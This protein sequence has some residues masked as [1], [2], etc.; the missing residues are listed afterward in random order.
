MWPFAFIIFFSAFLLFQVQPLIS[1]FILPWFGGS[2]SV[3][4]V[5]MLFFQLLLLLGYLYS[6][7]LNHFKVKTQKYVHL[8]LIFV[9][10]L[11]LPII[12]EAE[13]KPIDSSWP[14]IKIIVILFLTVGLPYFVL[15]TTGPLLQAWYVRKNPAKNPYI[16]Y[17]LSNAGSLIGLIS[18]P[19]LFEPFLDSFTQAWFWSGGFLLF[20]L[21]VFV[22]VFK[23]LKALPEKLF[24]ETAKENIK[25]LRLALWIIFPALASAIF[26][27]VTNHICL[28]VATIPFLW[29]LPFSLY[30]LTFIITFADPYFYKRGFYIAASLFC[31]AVVPFLVFYREIVSFDISLQ[32]V[33][34][35]LV[36]FVTC[37]TCHG[38]LYRL[39]PKAESLTYYYLMIAI[40]GALGGLFVSVIAPLIFTAYWELPFC[41]LALLVVICL[42]HFGSNGFKTEVS[43]KNRKVIIICF[44]LL[45][46]FFI[47]YII[48]AQKSGAKRTIAAQRNFYGTLRVEDIDSRE[49][50]KQ[51][52]YLLYGSTV[53]GNSLREQ[54]KDIPYL[55]YY[56]EGSGVG[57]L[58]EEIINT[59]NREVAL[60]GLGT[61]TLA[62]YGNEGDN[63][64]FY[65]IN[66]AVLPYAE[67][68]F[69]YLKESRAKINHVLGDARLSLEKEPN[70]KFDSLVLDAFSS[71]SIPVHLLTKEAFEMYLKKMKEKS[72][73]AVHISNRHLDLTPVLRALADYF[74]L[75]MAIISAPKDEAKKRHNSTWILL[76]KDKSILHSRELDALY[77]KEAVKSINIWTDHY[78]NLFKILK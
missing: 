48:Y 15:S 21:A 75:D 33:S 49:V 31:L 52:R 43:Y 67:Q 44:I 10:L 73:M 17:A 50:G 28:D 53:H 47:G 3:W 37:M 19:F 57:V 12:P 35:L 38:E 45:C 60:I 76:A 59:P 68:Y 61:G 71:D 65:E 7:I 27:A 62:Y 34:Y 13:W 30:L 29:I 77:T 69:S 5:A 23:K 54:G 24:I 42:K 66:P 25:P 14:A 22:L 1:K 26:L 39:K 63:F 64:T 55:G 58:M 2:A 46:V 6:F 40:G 8:F 20:G 41:I 32:V 51:E 74:D 11:T 56:A 9:T 78:S 36:L 16:L 70:N 72:V 4:L 18:F